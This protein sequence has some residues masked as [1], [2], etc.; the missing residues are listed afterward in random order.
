MVVYA[1]N[2]ISVVLFSA[3]A[4][5]YK[6]RSPINAEQDKRLPVMVFTVLVIISFQI[7]AGFRYDVGTDYVNYMLIYTEIFNK[8]IGGAT[9]EKI[10]IGFAI[11][12]K[13]LA[14]FTYKP[15]V[16]FFITSLFINVLIILELRRHSSCFWMACLMFILTSE[17]LTTL[18]IVRQAIA[19]AILFSAN[20][21]L[22]D[23]K[24][25]SYC[26]CAVLASLFHLSALI[27]IPVYFVVDKPAWS[28]LTWI[29]VAC[30]AV[31]YVLFSTVM[32]GLLSASS[33]TR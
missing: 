25:I 9:G 13:I 18:N 22:I 19:M 21:F 27:L 29:M 11:L 2:L 32:S 12:C 28:K 23:R 17:F 31:V 3:M 15:F 16:M 4:D 26:V 5:K 10:E 7:V 6:Y 14:F 33:A 24:F 1:A 8:G 30:T 20:R